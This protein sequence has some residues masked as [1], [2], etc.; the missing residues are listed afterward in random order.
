M[1]LVFLK[2]GGSLITDKSRPYTA[3]H[4]I[5][6]T[7]AKEIHAS[8]QAHPG[9]NLIIGHGAGSFGH[10]PAK[11]FR[12]RDGL[13]IER[14]ENSENQYWE[15]FAEVWFQASELN[16]HVIHAL[17]G[18]NVRAISFSPAASVFANDGQ[19]TLWETSQISSALSAGIV[20]VV[21]GDVIFDVKRGGTI[22]STEDLFMYLTHQLKPTRLL[23]AG[24]EDG[25]WAD[26]PARTKL[27]DRITPETFSEFSSSIGGSAADDVTGG[28]ET[29][30]KQM[31][32][33]AQE[34]SI[35]TV[36]IFSG[37]TPGNLTRA[38][39]G[40]AI[41]TTISK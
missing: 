31:L 21:Q 38:L 40:E 16:R 2:L 3:R 1:E 26:F 12:T 17:H 18:A 36:Q 5:M 27:V 34:T 24:I 7:M 33:L 32:Q 4:D 30:V 15:G 10:V 41:G 13:P 11:K 8:L 6:D 28:M 37:E 22:L 23:L 20:P 35:N 25:V 9:L 19:V 14:D 29:K 39:S